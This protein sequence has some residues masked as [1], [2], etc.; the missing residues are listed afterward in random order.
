MGVPYAKPPL[1]ELRWKE[2]QPASSWEG[3]RDATTHA[4]MCMQE[5]IHN[6][7]ENGVKGMLEAQS[8][9]SFR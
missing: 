5:A 3:I 6:P 7:G 2:T 9:Y 4:S 8:K 1:E